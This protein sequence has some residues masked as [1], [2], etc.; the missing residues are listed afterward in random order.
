MTGVVF[1]IKMLLAI[2]RFFGCVPQ[3]TTEEEAVCARN[4]GTQTRRRPR[5]LAIDNN[6]YRTSSAFSCSLRRSAAC[7]AFAFSGLPFQVAITESCNARPN[8]KLTGQG[9][10]PFCRTAAKFFVA[11]VASCPPLSS[12]TPAKYFGT[13]CFKTAAVAI[14][15]SFAVA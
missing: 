12:N 15:T 7:A 10:G 6:V 14:P 5:K 9:N 8:A 11:T 3:V 4:D 1:L 13:A 2:E